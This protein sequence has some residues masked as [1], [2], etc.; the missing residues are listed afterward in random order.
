VRPETVVYPHS[1][2]WH[3]LWIALYALQAVIVI[4]MIRRRLA[5]EFPMFLSY[6]IFAIVNEAILFILDHSTAV[7][8][9][10]YWVAYWIGSAL[11]IALRFAVVSEIFSHVFSP[12]PALG[13][14]SR[15]LFRWSAVV[16]A[17][18]GV[19][20]AAYVPGD[21]AHPIFSGIYV[22][23]R[24]TSLIQAGLLALLF[25]FASYFGLSWRSYAYGIAVGLGIFSTVDLAIAAMDAHGG[26]LGGGYYFDF[27]TMATYHCCV[28]IW[29]VYLLAPETSHRAVKEL[30]K[31][32]LEE[33]NAELQRL[34]LQ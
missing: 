34:L 16:L 11:S 19:V 4:V 9:E 5:R 23:D 2:L 18:V 1:F 10:Q 26:P 32:N 33:W 14:L 6:T 29:L 20:V 22:V 31:N 17:L 3:Y 27:V 12:Y 15:I 8:P 7:S 25:L 30:P 13:Q 21:A 24:G 28:V